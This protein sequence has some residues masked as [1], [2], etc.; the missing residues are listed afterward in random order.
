M[1]ML[2]RMYQLATGSSPAAQT[3]DIRQD[4][5]I[6]MMC[7][8]MRVT[9]DGAAPASCYV[10]LSFLSS[11]QYQVN[12]TTGVIW[13]TQLQIE[14]ATADV[15]ESWSVVVPASIPIS[16]GERLFLH[17]Q[18]TVAN[19]EVYVNIYTAKADLRPATRR[20]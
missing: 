4:D 9:N 7:F 3:I 20:R 8:N 6:A 1:T 14:S 13:S 11:S 19:V 16:S 2:Y 15:G 10:E 12:D 18:P 17:L 5:T